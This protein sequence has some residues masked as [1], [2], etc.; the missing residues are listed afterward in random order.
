MR[1]V[2]GKRVKEYRTK[3]GEER[4]RRRARMRRVEQEQI[5]DKEK[6]TRDEE[7]TSDVVKGIRN[8]EQ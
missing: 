7:R 1:K 4:N 8:E 6:R 3:D 5:R 2:S